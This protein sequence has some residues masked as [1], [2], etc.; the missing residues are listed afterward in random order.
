MTAMAPESAA[1]VDRAGAAPAAIAYSI[2]VPLF[3]CR[4]AGT[5]ALESAL[6]QAFPRARYE[7]IV[8]VDAR[9]NR[10]AL[11]PLLARC[12]SVVAVD[13]DFAAVESEIA[14][15]DAGSSVA[16]GEFLFFIEGHTVLATRALQQI[17]DTLA[18]DPGCALACGRRL[19][20]A[21][22]Q[23]GRADRRQQRRARIARAAAR[24]F[25]AR[26][27][28]RD[29]ALAVRR[30]RR[31]RCGVPAVQRDGAVPARARRGRARRHDRRRALYASQRRGF[32]LAR[33][34]ARR[35]RPCEG[36][37][38]RY[39]ARRGQDA[40]RTASGVSMAGIDVRGN[41]R[42]S[43]VADRRPFGDPSGHG[44]V[45][46][47]SG[48]A[49]RVFKAGIGLTDVSGFCAERAWGAWLARN[50]TA[51]ARPAPLQHV[52]AAPAGAA[53]ELERTA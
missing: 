30:T 13:A 15:L 53:I 3:D 28:L 50:R 45:S 42:S 39:A 46:P 36:A 8:V 7:V 38:L 33:P 29:T 31:I 22:T 12:D 1:G 47:F 9:S 11:L 48:A 5:R 20:H 24:Q 2:I 17:D 21:T 23:P 18:R 40:A 49:A 10:A 52:D 16:R 32:F 41:D 51:D 44:A 4:D 34:P 37:L 6:G 35:H 43:A 19:N 26:R 27:E 14:L 25:H